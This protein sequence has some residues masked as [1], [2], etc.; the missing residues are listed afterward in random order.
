MPTSSPVYDEEQDKKYNPEELRRAENGGG[1]K[2]PDTGD[3]E[4]KSLFNPES[5][6][7][8]PGDSSA[9]EN[10]GGS[11][12]G[13]LFSPGTEG[14]SG[15][16]KLASKLKGKASSNKVLLF[17]V[18]GGG[19]FFVAIII[20]MVMMLGNFKIVQ[21]AE[22]VAAYQ[23]ARSTN[24][25]TKNTSKINEAKIA[26]DSADDTRYSRMKEKVTATGAKSSELWSKLDKY[27]PNKI[28]SNFGGDGTLQ[29]DYGEPKYGRQRLR[30][31]TIQDRTILVQNN[32]VKDRLIPGYKFSKNI[33]YAQN[34]APYI[35]DAMK[36]NNIGPLT[37]ARVSREIRQK[38]GISLTAWVIGKYTG[39]TPEQAKVAV[40]EES[41]SK[42]RGEG[43]APGGLTSEKLTETADA[44]D[45]ANKQSAATEKGGQYTVDH[46]GQNAPE[47]QK[48]VD[49]ATKGAAGASLVSELVGAGNTLYA[50]AVPLCMVYEGS[51]Q[52]AGP[53][54]DSNTDQAIRAGVWMQSAAAQEKDGTNSTGE[55][56]GATDWKLGDI[57]NSNAEIRASGGR[58]DTSEYASNQA[59]PTGQY[60]LADAAGLGPE[61]SGSIGDAA[62]TICP[63]ATN[64]WVGAG[65]GVANLVLAA[66]TGGT[67][68][69][70]EEGVKV[71]AEKVVTSLTSRVIAK[72]IKTGALGKQ[73]AKDTVKSITLIE[74][75]TLIAK[76]IVINQMGSTHNTTS[77]G[78]D[79][80][81][82]LDSGTN[83]YAN[84]VNQQQFYGAPLQDKDLSSDNKAN[85]D[86]LAGIN[87]KKSAFE[88][89][90]S[91]ANPDSLLNK[92]AMGLKFHAGRQ[93][94][95]VLTNLGNN[96]LDPTRSMVSMFGTM[97]MPNAVA[98]NNIT[99]SNT[100]YGNVQF[101]FTQEEQDL[102]ADDSYRLLDNQMELDQSGSEDAIAAKYGKCF[103]GSVTIGSMLQDGLI[104][105]D[106][107]GNVLP[108]KGDC[109]PN[110]LSFNNNE[111]G[112]QMVF[113]WR[114]AQSY[115]NSF[116][117]LGEMQDDT[118][119][120]TTS[121]TGA[122]SGD[123]KSLAQQLLDR[124]GSGQ[125]STLDN[126]T[127][128]SVKNNLQDL[129]DGKNPKTSKQFKQCATPPATADTE[130]DPQLLKFLVDLSG[131]NKL[132]INALT[133]G[134][135]TA[136]SNHYKGKAVDLGC[137]PQLQKSV[138][139]QIG[140]KYGISDG[141]G[142]Y[143]TGG[144]DHWHYSIGGH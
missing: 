53:S 17:G 88:R 106:K 92:L 123:A 124:V 28:I 129:A 108:D 68:Q 22:H 75:A 43:K 83:A 81:N 78:T 54:I 137:S 87:S 77:V 128:A 20:L 84:K 18:G 95:S 9:K 138:I 5:E 71:A 40:Q 125:I 36:T 35:N 80:A 102:M 113:R 34:V 24:Q 93:S 14:K 2:K 37:R 51:L 44:A 60:S 76:A 38:L 105:R 104:E 21:F 69:A 86:Y 11:K 97:T 94:I 90:A 39:K 62:H 55:A 50:I 59:S 65:V 58:P 3:A 15:L 118:G 16:G 70:A 130:V 100:Y 8:K 47:A 119:D 116:D 74:G 30:G 1:E 91:S 109:S 98:A 41:T 12:S 45:E 48:I 110:K 134:C 82:T 73:F 57:Q 4:S 23:F 120:G 63:I 144:G 115:N 96:I 6:G 114:V 7:G 13:G 79:Y 143:C 85:L 33:K 141:T 25:M 103:D 126:G 61:L 142:E 31:I 111:F 72:L 64:I 66:V 117:Q 42:A 122:V 133:G 49:E 26:I 52:Y 121:D 127:G 140:S 32:P 19:L 56:V 89:Y 99:S 46:P 67:K 132:T 136:N 135:H 139:D 131:S 101:G 10:N 112:P 27:R 107:N 29:F